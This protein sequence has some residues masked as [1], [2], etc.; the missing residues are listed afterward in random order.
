MAE[1]RADEPR[2]SVH[3]AL[4]DDRTRRARA[5]PQ[6]ILDRSPERATGLLSEVIGF[7][8]HGLALEV[9]WYRHPVPS[10]EKER[11]AQDYAAYG[12]V[13]MGVRPDAPILFDPTAH[14]GEGHCAIPFHESFPGETYG[15]ERRVGEEAATSDEIVGCVKLEEE[16]LAERQGREG[17][18]PTWLPKVNL[19]EIP[20]GLEESEPVSVSDRNKGFHLARLTHSHAEH[21]LAA[22]ESIHCLVSHSIQDDF[23]V[24]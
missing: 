17:T 23:R 7:P 2:I 9:S 22:I 10:V 12:V 16:R 13:E 3:S 11:I 18:V 24:R 19:V 14:V 8:L 15:Q 1:P 6:P 20:L 21:L 5:P 4:M